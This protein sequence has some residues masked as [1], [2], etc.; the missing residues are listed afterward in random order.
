MTAPTDNFKTFLDELVAKIAREEPATREW[1]TRAATLCHLAPTSLLVVG[2]KSVKLAMHAP[3][4]VNQSSLA[5]LDITQK[6]R[7]RFLALIVLPENTQ[8]HMRQVC[9]FHV[10][11]MSINRVPTRLRASLFN[12]A[13]ISRVPLQKS[14]VPPVKLDLVETNRVRTASLVNFKMWPETAR[15]SS[16]QRVLETMAKGQRAA[17]AFHPVRMKL[18]ACGKNVRK[19]TNVK[20]KIKVVNVANVDRTHRH[21]AVLHVSRVHQAVL[22]PIWVVR[23]ATC[24]HRIHLTVPLIKLPVCP[25]V[26][27]QQQN[28][29]K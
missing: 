7:V 29:V 17:L 21:Q 26:L 9:A 18:V 12:L 5:I 20:E 23:S 6:Q 3:V 22:L 1:V 27:T 14:F 24:A 25:V 10:I 15:V 2:R 19:G 16:A 13:T 4:V 8:H 28:L 11:A